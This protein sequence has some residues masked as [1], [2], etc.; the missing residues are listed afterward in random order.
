MMLFA[1]DSQLDKIDN[2]F[3]RGALQHT[4]PTVPGP[5]APYLPHDGGN[6]Q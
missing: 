5:P 6:A 3:I 4:M 2:N 1:Y